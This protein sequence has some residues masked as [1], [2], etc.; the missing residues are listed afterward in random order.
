MQIDQQN[1]P[2]H[3]V[4]TLG[5]F[6]LPREIRN[7]DKDREEKALENQLV[8]TA[9][10]FFASKSGEGEEGK[11]VD[12]EALA[13]QKKRE[14]HLMQLDDTK[15]MYMEQIL[16]KTQ[17]HD[18]FDYFTEIVGVP[19]EA[20]EEGKFDGKEMI[21]NYKNMSREQ[22]RAKQ[23]ENRQRMRESRDTVYFN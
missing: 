20:D 10:G 16:R 8:S 9:K 1:K 6:K 15:R 13:V 4:E 22:I 12:R 17:Y 21:V 2:R 11:G 23:E 19:I 5:L 3:L 7:L 18:D 14:K